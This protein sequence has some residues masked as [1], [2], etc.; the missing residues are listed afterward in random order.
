LHSYPVALS[1]LD[2]FT[3][4]L[5]STVCAWLPGWKEYHAAPA[6]I[7]PAALL[8]NKIPLPSLSSS[9]PR[10]LPRRPSSCSHPA[11]CASPVPA[12][13]ALDSHGSPSRSFPNR[14]L[15]TSS[16]FQRAQ[17]E[18]P[19]VPQSPQLPLLPLLGLLSVE[20]PWSSC[21]SL[22]PASIWTAPYPEFLLLDT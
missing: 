7:F 6:L 11:L 14:A 17:H 3:V 20:S 21:T 16:S 18:L 19:C 4:A 10:Q 12:R 8:Q 1:P 2:I 15:P 13:R 5:S 22:V 9:S